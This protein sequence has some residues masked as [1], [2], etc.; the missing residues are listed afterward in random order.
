[1]GTGFGEQT[2]EMVV[3]SFTGGEHGGTD[4]DGVVG[5]GERGLI[6]GLR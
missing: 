2:A 6:G 1:M 4:E 3:V 5:R